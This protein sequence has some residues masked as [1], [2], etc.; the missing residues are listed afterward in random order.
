MEIENRRTERT[1]H[2]PKR[3]ETKRKT[4]KQEGTNERINRKGK[5]KKAKAI[6]KH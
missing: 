5:E 1:R 4:R 2:E 3:N 6:G